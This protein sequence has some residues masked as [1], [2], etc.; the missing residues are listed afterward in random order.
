MEFLALRE[1]LKLVEQ[2][3]FLPIK[4]NTDSTEVINM[5]TND[6]LLYH[7][8]LDEC[9][10]RLRSIGTPPV[11]HCY[12]EQN[13]VA[14]LL[15]KKGAS[16]QITSEPVILLVSP[17]FAWKAVWVDNVGTMFER[18]IPRCNEPQEG[19]ILHPG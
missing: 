14:D 2:F 12:R 3:N 6:N 18:N 19:V 11:Q 4:I 1:G 15:A 5:L 7:V 9:R 17:L 8:F 16:N 10:S 13:Q